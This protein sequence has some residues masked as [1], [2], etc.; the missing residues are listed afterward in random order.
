MALGACFCNNDICHC[1][2]LVVL[3]RPSWDQN[4]GEE[5]LQFCL[6]SFEALLDESVFAAIVKI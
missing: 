3:G 4:R 1:D 2:D 5:H 6:H